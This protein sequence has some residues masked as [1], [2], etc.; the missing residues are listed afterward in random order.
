MEKTRDYLLPGSILFAA[1]VIAGAVFYSTTA[2]N[3][4]AAGKSAGQARAGQASAGAAVGT[5]PSVSADDVVLGDPNAPVT[6][7]EFSDFQCPFCGRYYSQTL[8]LIR[9][10][11]VETGKVKI[12]HKDFA[13]LGAESVA[14]ANAV[15]C[16]KDQG[17]YFQYHDRIYDAE[18][19]DGKMNNGNLNEAL[20]VRI[21][22]DLGMDTSKFSSC[23]KER[24][25]DNIV[26]GNIKEG[27]AAMGQRASTPTFFINGRMIQ[28][29]LPYQTF[30]QAI[31]ALLEAR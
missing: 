7:I 11:Y 25:Y 8:P 14:A 20:F 26:Q 3:D 16:A 21:A 15:K 4:G 29:A 18:I 24:K 12:V 27:Q 6:I 31:D 2:K 30:A 28:G 17:K 23:Y 10:N 22:N 19:P 9:K 1:L 13:F 5:A